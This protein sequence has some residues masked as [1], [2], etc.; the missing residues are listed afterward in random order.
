M[1][2]RILY[3]VVFLILTILV[4]PLVPII[5]IFIGI[6]S[7]EYVI[8]G[9]LNMDLSQ[10]QTL[11]YWK[12]YTNF[13]HNIVRF[14]L[15]RSLASG[16]SVINV[17]STGMLES[18]KIIVPSI[19]VSYIIGTLI[20]VL[21][22]R[23]KKISNIWNKLQFIFYIP[24]IIISYLF[25]YFLS[26]IGIN[27]L[28]NVRYITAVVVLS[29]YPI[30]IITNALKKTLRELES[31]DFF[32]FHKALGFETNEIWK[33]FC[34]RFIIIDYLAF[35]ENIVIFMI[36]FIFFVEMPFGIQGMGY[37]FVVAIQRF[38]YPVII[39]FCIF[40]IFLL[41]FIGLVVEIIKLRLD[42]RGGSV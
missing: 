29:I 25:L 40:G 37:K 1:H 13:L 2:R 38:D 28:S 11:S 15:G 30:Y 18:L 39:G 20:G 24:M 14:N 32:L 6:S 10:I 9:T 17:V 23:S 7:P 21:V 36:G 19:I 12:I 8:K 34:Y 35:F 26:F 22:E 31:S 27:F 33:K 5:I 41:S 3:R 42:P 4:I 16:K